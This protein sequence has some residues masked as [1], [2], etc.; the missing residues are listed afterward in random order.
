MILVIILPIFAFVKKVLKW[1]R[2]GLVK[3]YQAVYAKSVAYDRSL[4]YNGS[5]NKRGELTDK[6]RS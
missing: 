1:K 4:I 6:G 3:N 5:I 2:S